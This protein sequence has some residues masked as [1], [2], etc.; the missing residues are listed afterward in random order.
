M[1]ESLDF[2]AV[3]RARYA[4]CIRD[5]ALR[6]LAQ[7]EQSQ[8]ELRRK[9]QAVQWPPREKFAQSGSGAAAASPD[10]AARRQLIDELIAEL[11]AADLQS[12]ARFAEYLGQWRFDGGAGPVK[13]RY[14]L[15]QHQ[16]NQD[17]TERVMAKYASKWRARADAVRRRKFGDAPPRNYQDWARQA[18]FLQ[19]RGFT[20]EQ[21]GV[22]KRAD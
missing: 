2:A 13:L 14:E 8:S 9:L 20:N 10:P 21:I 16:L 15:N 7:R 1:N 5:K 17:L 3:T 18:R 11:S 12:D 4:Q 22:Y 19:Q 6:L